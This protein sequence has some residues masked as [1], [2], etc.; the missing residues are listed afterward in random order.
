MQL[1]ITERRAFDLVNDLTEAGYVIKEGT[2]GATGITFRITCRSPM[3]RTT[4]PSG[5]FWRRFS[6]QR[7]RQPSLR[8]ARDDIEGRAG[9]NDVEL[10]EVVVMETDAAVRDAAPRSFR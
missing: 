3:R 6:R 2:A 9:G 7:R 8:E 5:T 10:R 1:G 4:G